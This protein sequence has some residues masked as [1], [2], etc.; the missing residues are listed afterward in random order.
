M[1]KSIRE[2]KVYFKTLLANSLGGRMPLCF[3]VFMDSIVAP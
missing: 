3:L 1:N 2:K